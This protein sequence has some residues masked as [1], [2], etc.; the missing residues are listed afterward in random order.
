[1]KNDKHDQNSFHEKNLQQ[2]QSFHRR[3]LLRRD[4][5]VLGEKKITEPTSKVFLILRH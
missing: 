5:Q 3:G 1:M 4:L 2:I